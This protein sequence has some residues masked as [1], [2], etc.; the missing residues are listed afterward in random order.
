MN[1]HVSRK[2]QLPLPLEAYEK[3][4]GMWIALSEDGSRIIA[5]ADDL[6]TLEDQLAAL[7]ENPEKAIF[8]RV[9]QDDFCL[10]GAEL[11]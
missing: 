1:P 2:A 4:R 8:D 5:G 7:G 6:E 11:L 9:E 10:G 3:Y